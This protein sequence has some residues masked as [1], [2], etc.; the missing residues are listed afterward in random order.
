MRRLKTGFG[1]FQR[2]E[3]GKELIDA[4]GIEKGPDAF[5]DADDSYFVAFV[6]L[7]YVRIDD[8]AEASGV[9]VLEIGAVENEEVGVNCVELGLQLED[10]KEG[11]STAEGEHG[12]A[13]ICGGPEGVVEL[14]LGHPLRIETPKSG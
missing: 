7:G 3:P 14:V 13:G 8:D 9:H 4:S 5:G 1:G 11:E 2:G 12:A 6:G 10:V